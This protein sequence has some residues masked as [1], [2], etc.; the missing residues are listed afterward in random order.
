M[1]DGIAW[2]LK[3]LEFVLSL[4]GLAF[5]ISVL[6]DGFKS[7]SHPKPLVPTLKKPAT[8]AGPVVNTEA[9]RLKLEVLYFE[10]KISLDVMQEVM[11]LLQFQKQPSASAVLETPEASQ[12]PAPLPIARE[13]LLASMQLPSR[14]TSAQSL[15]LSQHPIEKTGF[16]SS[17]NI[18]TLLLSGAALFVLSAYLFVRSYWS[19]IP[20]FVKFLVLLA[21]AAGIYGVG[22]TLWGNNKTPK[23][24]ETLLCVGLLLIPLVVFGANV[25]LLGHV[26]TPAQTWMAGSVTMF[27]AAC[28]TVNIARTYGLAAM[29]S[30]SFMA[31]IHGISW[32]ANLSNQP[33]LFWLSTGLLALIC[34][35]VQ[36]P[37][38]K[39]FQKG[40]VDCANVFSAIVFLAY[41]ANSFYW[42]GESQILTAG[43]LI[44]L[45][46][47]FAIQA[48]F[49]A[50]SWA[51]AAG[52]LFMLSGAI[53]LRH[54]RVPIHNFGLY[55]IPAGILMMLRAW[56]FEQKGK[57]ELGAPYFHLSQLAIMGSIASVS[58]TFFYPTDFLAMISIL[59]LGI[60]AYT[61]AGLL[62][63]DSTFSYIGGLVVFFMV[64]I[65]IA[66][67]D[68]SFASAV[69]WLATAASAFVVLSLVAGG[70]SEEQ[71]G[72]PFSFLGIGGLSLILCLVAGKWVSQ[73]LA[74]GIIGV[75]LP[76]EQI[77]AGLRIGGLGIAAYLLMAGVKRQVQYVY[78]TLASATLF[79]I[80][81][82]QYL[83]WPIDL[84][85]MSWIVM[86][87]IGLFYAAQAGGWRS[88]SRCFALWAQFVLLAIGVS[89]V[90]ANS[91]MG[92]QSVFWCFIVFLPVLI[93]G[94]EDLMTSCLLAGYLSHF[95]WFRQ[96][97]IVSIWDHRIA[98]YALQL[99]AV[100]CGVVFV[101]TLIR[102]WRPGRSVEPFRVLAVTFSVISL[103]LSLSDKSVAWQVYLA[104]GVLAIL[105]SIVHYEGKYL[106]LGTSLLVVSYEL[107][108]SYQGVELI[109]A[110]TVPAALHLLIWGFVLRDSRDLRNLLYAAGQF[111]L[112]VP[113]LGKSI[114]E[115]W[116]LHGVFLGIASLI[117]M[118]F[119]MSQRNRCL[120]SGSFGILI[121]NGMIQSQGFLRSVPRWIY[122]GVS[123]SLLMALGGIFEFHRE[124]LLRARQRMADTLDRWD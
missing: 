94:S 26:W 114:S 84:W 33:E 60:L 77:L 25:L 78:P 58:G 89:A 116:E 52:F 106:G 66:H 50:P 7:A 59:T 18:K 4:M 12:M 70:W 15:T 40:L 48:R 24:A 30:F 83:H 123:G 120:T 91:A 87:S 56:M 90:I 79:Y 11:K 35:S 72:L 88:L 67:Y 17:E 14:K 53:G 49:F 51:Y 1:N 65:S 108:L 122:L 64:G 119:G 93:V 23:T 47:F 112:F 31:V 104:Y 68:L 44:A 45:G 27:L 2:M 10:K 113:S 115:H 98:H 110:Y 22:W 92:L 86:A 99:V 21:M 118:V 73:F 13:N 121:L 57:A 54:V 41:L 37:L 102:A 42:N 19:F 46:I 9:I 81:L 63:R 111:I 38:G 101:R 100:N 103:M 95:L 80:Y 43:G 74:E 97:N 3:V 76:P 75:T 39:T 62:T 36:Q 124:W 16:F 61:L 6:G 32:A 20:D 5:I 34:S 85:H 105:V 8:K 96:T 55:F 69:F 117:V 107:F 71:I 82:L 29:V 28:L 109:E